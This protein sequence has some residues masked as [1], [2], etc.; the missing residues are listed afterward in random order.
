[1]CTSNPCGRASDCFALSESKFHC[2]CHPGYEKNRNDI[3]EKIIDVNECEMEND[4]SENADCIDTLYSQG[5][6][7]NSGK[8]HFKTQIQVSLHCYI[9]P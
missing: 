7:Q 9:T 1:M 2:V 5:S 8:L 4:C 6:K 3:C